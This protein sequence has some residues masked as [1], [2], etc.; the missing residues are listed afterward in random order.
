MRARSSGRMPRARPYRKLSSGWLIFSRTRVAGISSLV[1]PA[2]SSINGTAAMLRAPPPASRST[3]SEIGGRESS[4]KPPSTARAGLR[5][6][7]RATSSWNSFAPLGSLLPCPTMRSAVPP[8]SSPFPPAPFFAMVRSRTSVLLVIYE[9]IQGGGSDSGAAFGTA[10]GDG[11]QPTKE[12]LFLGLGGAD[13]PD[14]E[15]DNEC[16]IRAQIHQLEERRGRVADDPNGPTP[17]L[18]RRDPEPRRRAG[19]AEFIG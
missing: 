10:I 14:R 8:P 1:W 5:F 9:C 18:F 17:Y 12:Q 13:E 11:G 15:P 3:H 6:L 19:N 7:V 4:M 16:W 2:A